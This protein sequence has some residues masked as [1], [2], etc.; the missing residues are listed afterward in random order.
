MELQ[1][2][3]SAQR[4]LEEN[5]QGLT[6]IKAE[7]AGLATEFHHGVTRFRIHLLCYLGRYLAGQPSDQEGIRWV[8]VGELA[9]YPL[10]ATGRKFADWLAR[11]G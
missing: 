10:S 6:G 2:L 11:N 5:I 3:P 1:L 9:D 4:R 7:L 8:S